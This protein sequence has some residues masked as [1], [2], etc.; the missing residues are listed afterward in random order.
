[1]DK[2]YW[3]DIMVVLHWIRKE[4][5]GS[6]FVGNR[7]KNIRALSDPNKLNYVPSP[8]NPAYFHSRGCNVEVSCK[9]STRTIGKEPLNNKPQSSDTKAIW[10][11][12]SFF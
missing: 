10:I 8:L 7:V 1:M 11:S 9:S 4:D 12:T 5:P 6:D 3:S 2:Y